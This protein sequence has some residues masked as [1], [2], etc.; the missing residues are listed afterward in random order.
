[1][2]NHNPEASHSDYDMLPF[3]TAPAANFIGQLVVHNGWDEE[4]ATTH[5]QQMVRLAA[6][7]YRHFGGSEME[8]PLEGSWSEDDVTG[9]IEVNRVTFE[10]HSDGF[11]SAASWLTRRYLSGEGDHQEEFANIS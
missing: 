11:N 8:L 9:Y 2:S 1:M 4:S 7:T 10:I 3:V 5:H 6:H